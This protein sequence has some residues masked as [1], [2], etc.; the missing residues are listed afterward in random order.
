MELCRAVL[1]TESLV[2]ITSKRTP[3]LTSNLCICYSAVVSLCTI[4][5]YLQKV[6]FQSF[7][8]SSESL[9]RDCF[10]IPRCAAFVPLCFYRL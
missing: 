9:K 8:F 3:S 7:T 5:K 10:E 6:N 4:R 2:A 1:V